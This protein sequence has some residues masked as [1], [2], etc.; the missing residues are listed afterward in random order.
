MA[1]GF[2]GGIANMRNVVGSIGNDIP[3]RADL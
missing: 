3:D 1:A 2:R